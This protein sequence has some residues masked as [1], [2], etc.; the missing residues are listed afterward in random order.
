MSDLRARKVYSLALGTNLIGNGGGSVNALVELDGLTGGTT[1]NVITLSSNISLTSGSAIFSGYGRIVLADSGGQIYDVVLPG[2]QMTFLG[3]RYINYVYAYGFAYRGFGIAE[4]I[5]TNIWL[6]HVRDERTIERLRVSDGATETIASFNY[7]GNYAGNF[8]LCL[9]RNRWYFN[10][11]NGSQF[12]GTSQNN[13]I[14]ADATFVYQVPSNTPPSFIDQPPSRFAPVS[15]T[16]VLSS[17]TDGSQPLSYQWFLQ[18]GLLPNQTNASLVLTNVHATAEGAY[19]LVLSNYAGTATSAVATVAIDYGSTTTNTVAL[20]TLTGS[21]WRYHNST[22]FLSSNIAW[23]GSNYNDTSWSGSGL[24]LLAVESSASIT[25]L[26]NTTL[27]LGRTSYYFRAWFNVPTNYVNGTL[28]RATTM[29]D[30]GATIYLNGHQVERV[31]MPTGSYGPT[32]FA[33]TQAPFAGDAGLEYFYWLAST[34]LVRGSNVIA[35][36]VHQA[37]AN[38]SDIVWGLALD[39]LVPTLNRPPVI[40]NQPVSQIVSNGVTVQMK[41]GASGNAPLSYQWRFNGTNLPGAITPT[42]TI[43]NVQSWHA[44]VYSARVSNPYD[45]AVSSNASLTVLVPPMTRFLP[46]GLTFSAPGHFMLNFTGDSNSV[47]AIE[48]STN[49]INWVQTGTITNTTGT[50]SYDD[51][52]A[53]DAPYRFYR[54]RLVP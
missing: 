48:T 35:A 9:P 43:T 8:T 17:V 30:D 49:L 6:A 14:S 18:G 32:T 3:Q 51:G 24:G 52:S 23:T 37:S 7:L 27:I 16:V 4:Y 28:L 20:L 25:P 53:G 46:A 39:A 5:G 12:G 22:G 34:N 10:C 2:G 29:I 50:V 1:T 40:T 26:I 21:T 42:L 31:R 19:T 41:T 38:S 47:I 11:E 13:L 15:S 54:L 45:V 36:E 33:P 44:G